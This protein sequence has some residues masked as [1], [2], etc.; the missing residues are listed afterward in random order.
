LVNV[1]GIILGIAAATQDVRLIL[2]GG[3]AATFAESIAMGAVA[4][5]S[6]LARHQQYLGE[7]EREKREMMDVP[8]EERDEVRVVLRRWGF[9]GQE[10]D[11][12]VERITA[13]PRA[14]LEFMMAYELNLAPVDKSQALR[15][16]LTV[17][18]AALLGS[19]VPLSPFLLLPSSLLT[20][21][22][23]AV[24]ASALMLFVV[25]WYKAKTTVGRPGRS[26]LQMVLIGMVA[27]LAG[28]AIGLLFG[29]PAGG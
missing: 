17:G 12:M 6:T 1:L 21:I 29:A 8:H 25:G 15:S 9:E 4:Y 19:L 2:A 10:L 16:A 28:F 23:A 24:T 14:W 11:E 18:T 3:L 20:G 26:G 13:K 22:V 7:V 5:T 27:A